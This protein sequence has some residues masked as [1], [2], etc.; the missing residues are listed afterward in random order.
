V[1]RRYVIPLQSWFLVLAT[2]AYEFLLT[3]KRGKTALI[4][5]NR[6]KALNAL[7]NELV[8]ELTCALKQVEPARQLSAC[9]RNTAAVRAFAV[10]RGRECWMRRDHWQREGLRRRSRQHPTGWPRG[11]FGRKS[12]SAMDAGADIKF[13]APECRLV[14][15]ETRRDLLQSVV[16]CAASSLIPPPSCRPSLFPPL[17]LSAARLC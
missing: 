15:A 13:M 11:D 1:S 4:T 5:L 14:Y 8:G 10:R 12:A 17:P 6:P 7:N 16:H 2:A 3:E 9:I